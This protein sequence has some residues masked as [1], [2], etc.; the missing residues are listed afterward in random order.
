MLKMFEVDHLRIVTVRAPC[1][2]FEKVTWQ[3]SYET[4]KYTAGT[5]H[6]FTYS[7]PFRSFAGEKYSVSLKGKTDFIYHGKHR[8][9]P[10]GL[11]LRPRL[12]RQMEMFEPLS[13]VLIIIIGTVSRVTDRQ[14]STAG[15]AQPTKNG[16]D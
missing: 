8:E 6:Y 13:D 3:Y 7:G 9:V 16:R 15:T 4:Q 5:G 1:Q 11:P 10:A 12:F 14:N 2:K